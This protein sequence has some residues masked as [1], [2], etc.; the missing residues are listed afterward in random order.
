LKFL[1]LVLFFTLLSC[2]NPVLKIYSAQGV[3]SDS[4][5]L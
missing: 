5:L 1:T 2:H 3:G 4:P